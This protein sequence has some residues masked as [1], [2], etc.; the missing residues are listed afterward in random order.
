MYNYSCRVLWSDE[1][2]CFIATCPEFPHLSAFGDTRQEALNELNVVLEA[3]IDVYGEEGW[4]LPEPQK[5]H[6]YSGQFRLRLSKGLHRKLAIQ[7]ESEGVSLN[8]L[9]V[10][11]LSE[12]GTESES[13]LLFK[14]ELH[15]AFSWVLNQTATAYAYFAQTSSSSKS[16]GNPVNVSALIETNSASYVVVKQ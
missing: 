2:E 10:Q 15:Q 12:R 14:Q 8:T 9:I 13:R 16:Y 5:V 4:K 1:D 6:E 7:A 11:Y 3:A